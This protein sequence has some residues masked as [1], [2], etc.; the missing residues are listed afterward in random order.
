MTSGFF[1]RP[2]VAL[3]A[4]LGA[5][6]V[7]AGV[8]CDAISPRPVESARL[9]MQLLLPRGGVASATAAFKADVSVT[10][11]G[12]ATP[13][14]GTFFF[15]TSGTA[16]ATMT[17]PVGTPRILTISIFDASNVLLFMGTSTISVAPGVNPPATVTI[18]PS[19][20]TVPIVVTVGTFVVSVTPTSATFAVGATQAFSATVL[21]PTGA[22]SATPAKWATANPAIVQVDSVTG[23]AT[24][25]ISGTTTITATAFGVAASATVTIP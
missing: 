9:V 25:R 11:P 6:I 21:T 4:A 19:A 16:T 22:P 20:G 2:R 18:V 10:G 24:G 7:S 1:S 12:I 14:V 13:I 5:M 8:A 3:V 23:V 17:I 15:D